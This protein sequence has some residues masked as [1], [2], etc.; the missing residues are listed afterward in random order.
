M[1]ANLVNHRLPGLD[2]RSAPW[3]SPWSWCSICRVCYPTYWS[4]RALWVDGR[5]PVF[6]AQRLSDWLATAEAGAR[7]PGR[8]AAGFL[9][10][11][12]LPHPAGVPG[13]AGALPFWPLWREA[14]GMSP[15]WQ[16]LTFTE[17]FFVDYSVNQAFSH[18][19]SLCVEEHFY[20]LLP[21]IVLLMSRKAAAWKTIALLA[22]FVALGLGDS[23]LCIFPRAAADGAATAMSSG[24]GTS[25]A[26]TTR[27]TRGWMDCWQ[28]WRSR[29]C[30]CFRPIWWSRS[31]S[32]QTGCWRAASC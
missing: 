2:T 31:C 4:D 18:V 26:S 25:N 7:R 12:G 3:P 17:N 15:L 19:W 11:A 8:F 21:M 10:Q 13:G 22:F 6:R 32:A 14:P 5:G 16:F 9:P 29:S 24:C 27:R 20:L 28:A 1:T 30:G 23:Q